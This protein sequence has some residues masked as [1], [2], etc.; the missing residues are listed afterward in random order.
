MSAI[1][2]FITKCFSESGEVSFGRTASFLC[3]VFCLGWD[4]A[5]LF[6]VFQH[7]KDLHVQ[8]GDLWVPAATLAGQG[9]FCLGFY[10]VNKVKSGY[11]SK[12]NAGGSN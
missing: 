3:L 7:W 2:N 10:T 5:S 4:S 12:V 9:A 8:V 1:W 11:D 6:F